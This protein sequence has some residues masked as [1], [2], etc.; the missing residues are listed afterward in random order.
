MGVG[1]KVMRSRVY[2]GD[3]LVA[4]L[5]TI[6]DTIER[7]RERYLRLKLVKIPITL[8]NPVSSQSS[9]VIQFGKKITLSCIFDFSERFFLV[10]FFRVPKAFDK[11]VFDVLRDPRT[12]QKRVAVAYVMNSDNI[13]ERVYAHSAIVT[14][15]SRELREQ[16][17]W[18]YI[19]QRASYPE[20]TEYLLNLVEEEVTKDDIAYV[21]K[22]L[23]TLDRDEMK[24]IRVDVE[25]KNIVD[26]ASFTLNTETKEL[27]TRI[28]LGKGYC[29][30]C[31]AY[32]C[33]KKDGKM[34]IRPKEMER[35]L[36][37]FCNTG[38]ASVLS[39]TKIPEILQNSLGKTVR[40]FMEAYTD[41]LA[42]TLLNRI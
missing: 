1:M 40:Y 5:E 20:I 32:V 39:C 3:V 38:V 21:G 19:D 22:T 4:D 33:Y 17:W 25:T 15:L 9:V 31:E 23:K 35:L 16:K 42:K 24:Y 26:E 37:V 41:T 34:E 28:V 29:S 8:K 13:V 30:G 6:R 2:Q 36:R 27:E 11:L 14:L 7:V 10:R 18:N 12:G